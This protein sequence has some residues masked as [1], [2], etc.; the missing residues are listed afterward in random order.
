[1]GEWSKRLKGSLVLYWFG[2]VKRAERKS[3]AGDLHVNLC[4]SPHLWSRAVGSDP[5]N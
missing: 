4:S 3:K 1:M 2:V 5:E